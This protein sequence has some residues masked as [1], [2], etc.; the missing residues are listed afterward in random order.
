MKTSKV[1]IISATIL[2]F[3]A[4]IGFGIA[5]GGD[6]Q[7]IGESMEGQTPQA[8]MSPADDLQLRN[9]T[10]TGSLSAASNADSSK[11][12]AGEYVERVWKG[13]IDGH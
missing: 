13:D 8:A 11:V 1:G 6:T 4:M 3:V 10:E 7:T 9:P 2:V 12:E 5:Q